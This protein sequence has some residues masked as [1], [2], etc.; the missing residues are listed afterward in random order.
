MTANKVYLLKTEPNVVI[1]VSNTMVA[2]ILITGATGLI[3]RHLTETLLEHGY[4]V[5]QLS[6]REITPKHPGIKVFKW[7]V[8]KGKIDT[9]CIDG[10]DAVIHL[11]GE[12]LGA[13][14]WTNQRKKAI[15]ES[16]TRSIGLIYDL[17]RKNS[18]HQVKTVISASAVGFYGDH[19]NDMLTESS[20]PGGDFLAE[21]CMAWETAVDKGKKLGLR[22]VKFRNGIVLARDGGALPTLAKPIRAGF[23]APLGSGNQWVPWIHVRDLVKMFMFA[24]EHR[25]LEGPYNAASPNPVTNKFLTE[26]LAQRTN[27]KVWLPKVPAFLL[28]AILGRMSEMVLV[29]AKTSADKILMEGFTFTF[30]TLDK[31]LDDLYSDRYGF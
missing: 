4:L 14:P 22:V 10:A 18:N 28:R 1:W 20:K 15:I 31:A 29:S 16:R 24:L 23:G 11:A 9:A 17:L 7:D 19:G 8:Y 3:G 13:K 2:T 12:N 26:A 30:P 27:S 6:R 5:N 25:N 21:T